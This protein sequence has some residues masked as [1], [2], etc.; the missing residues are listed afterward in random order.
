M[1]FDSDFHF[2]LYLLIMIL[3]MIH[4]GDDYEASN[5]DYC[6]IYGY[7]YDHG[8]YCGCDGNSYDGGGD[9]VDFYDDN[10]VDYDYNH[11]NDSNDTD[12][13]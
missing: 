1:T 2:I 6:N 8:D 12:N 10:V 9:A 7:R 5:D 3:R 4:D 11:D 13:D